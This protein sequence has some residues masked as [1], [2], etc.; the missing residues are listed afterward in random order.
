MAGAGGGGAAAAA[1]AAAIATMALSQVQAQQQRPQPARVEDHLLAGTIA[2]LTSTG[3]LFPLDLIKTHYQ[4]YDHAGKPYTS[5]LQVGG[6]GV[7]RGVVVLDGLL[8]PIAIRLLMVDWHWS[9]VPSYLPLFCP[10]PPPHTNTH[11]RACAP[12]RSWRDTG[13]CTRA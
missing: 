6:C 4:V 10:Q 8:G 13:G 1:A 7:C 12:S 5:L 2:G 3:L 9:L 11:L